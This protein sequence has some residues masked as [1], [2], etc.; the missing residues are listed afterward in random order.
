MNF[1]KSLLYFNKNTSKV[2]KRQVGVSLNVRI[3]NNPKKYLG[4]PTMVGRRKKMHSLRF[5]K[6]FYQKFKLEC[7]KSLNQRERRFFKIDITSITNSNSMQCFKLPISLCCELGNIINR[8][9]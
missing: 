7:L 9:W 5:G 1:D 4:L 3:T 6:D 8:F 2:D